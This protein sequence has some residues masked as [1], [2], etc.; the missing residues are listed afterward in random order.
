MLFRRRAVARPI[1]FCRHPDLIRK[2]K[3][4]RLIAHF[5]FV[6]TVRTDMARSVVVAEALRSDTDLA[7]AYLIK[8]GF[9]FFAV[10]FVGLRRKSLQIAMQV[11]I[12]KSHLPTFVVKPDNPLRHIV[13][14]E[15][16][17]RFK[18]VFVVRTF[19][20]AFQFAVLKGI[21]R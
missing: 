5:H 12:R 1:V 18:A 3:V 13:P 19:F 9:V 17:R 20:A 14:V 11:I 8:N 21:M 4:F 6:V 7:V 16:F 2:D 10:F 15:V